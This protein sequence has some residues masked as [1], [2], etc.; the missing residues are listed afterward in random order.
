MDEKYTTPLVIKKEKYFDNRGFFTEIF[1]INN[2]NFSVVQINLSSSKKGVL[3][4]L[5]FQKGSYAQAKYI[6]VIKGK[7]FDV[8]V[9]LR[10]D[11]SMFGKWQ[12]YELS[13][14]ND[15]S[16]FVPRGFAHGFQAIEDNTLV[17][18]AVDNAYN[19]EEEAGIRYDDPELNITWP[20]SN[21]IISKKDL[22]WPTLKEAK[23]LGY[24]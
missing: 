19:P 17:L 13:D 1:N 7:I 3:R 21:P 4:G 5:H 9:D 14:D 12:S 2:L 23:R 11:S 22:S 18:Y 15:L 6:S 24:F 10:Q 16:L 8:V 20:I